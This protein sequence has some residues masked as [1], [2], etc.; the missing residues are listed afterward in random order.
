[1]LRIRVLGELTLELDGEALPPP[2][3]RRLRAL[4]G[5]LALHPGMHARAE[6]AGRLWPDV[7]DESARTSLR[8]A[9]AD[10]RRAVGD[11]HVV[12][13][14]DAVGLAPGVWIDARAFDELVAE[15]RLDE[16]LALVRGEVLDG[17][18]EEWVYAERDRRGEAVREALRRLAAEAE[19]AGDLRTAIARTR[20][21]IVADPLAE[22]AHRDLI[23]RL[24]AAGDRP[25]A[26]SAYIQLRELLAR[27]LQIAP[28]AQTRALVTQIH[29]TET[30]AAA[31]P[32]LPLPPAL[33]RRHRSPFV[34]RPE[35]LA[36]LRAAFDRAGDGRRLVLLTGEPGIGK[37][38]LAAE[39][40]RAVHG[41]GAT[42]LY[43]RAQEEPL[44]PYQPF[45]EALGPF[46]AARS[47]DALLALAGP[48]A[49][50]LGRLVPAEV[51]RLPPLVEAAT[52]DPA[53]ARYRLFEAAAALVAGAAR[54]RPLLLVLDDLHWADGPT[55]LLL[56]HLANAP[57][58]PALVLGTYRPGEQSAA[59][60]DALADLRREDR[61]DRIAVEGLVHDDV[62]ALVTAWLGRDAP[63]AL[64]DTVCR[65]TDGNPFFVEELL[66]QY[67]ESDAG[68]RR[69]EP[70]VPEG[71][72]EVL[73]RRLAR[74][75]DPARDTLL[76]AAVAGREVDLRLLEEAGELP[77]EALVEAL[78]AGLGAHLIREEAGA[79]GRYAFTHA[80]AREAIYGELSSARRALLHGR[81]A[82]AL[83]S[84]DADAAELAH[85]FLAAGGPRENVIEHAG[86]AGRRALAQ[87]AYEEAARH[88]ER[89]LDL[90][91]DAGELLIGLGDARL[92]AGDVEAS[93]ESFSSAAAVARRRR[94]GELLARAALGRSGLGATVLGHDPET[95]AVLEDALATLGGGSAALRARLLGRLAIELYHSPPV[96]RREELSA[97][98][99]AL[100]REA[101]DP[102]A[103]ADALSARHV[104]LWSPPHLDERLAL[105]DEMVALAE[106][107][108]DR[109]H[110]LQGRNWRVLDLLER[111]DLDAARREIDEHGR[112]ADDLRL[113][114]YQWWTPM[115][116]AMLAF[117]EGRL[118][119]AER[120]RAEAVEI[121]RRA[122]DRVADLFSWIQTVFVDLESEPIAP[123]APTDVPDRLA[124][125]AVQSAFRSD[126]PLIYAEM[127]R[128]DDARRE[129]EALAA[130]RFAGVAGDM[131]WLA[132]MVE[133]GQG[134]ALL[135]AREH[136][137]ELYE[138][139]LPYRRRSVLV[140]RAALCLG[141]VELH[142][143]VLATALGRYDDAERHLDAAARWAAAAGARPWA[144]WTDVHRAELLA[145]RGEAEAAAAL[146]GQAASKAEALGWGRAAGRARAVVSRLAEPPGPA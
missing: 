22:D 18:A 72:R 97:Q 143:G 13:T 54:E 15:R 39:L 49:G 69:W 138:L 109:E 43:G 129:L 104:A 118:Q 121:G 45:A 66:R 127:G 117:L 91:P 86:R 48:L 42:V 78:D 71:V 128:T 56:R 53:G 120:L 37:T 16:A 87:L 145:A 100:A 103:L 57:L 5:W 6:V 59:L 90:A 83:E 111:G 55:L 98:A 79:P 8:T 137:A 105:A 74:L 1:M 64:T 36:T 70:I 3:G 116:G 63:E 144:A 10:L 25:A 50:E 146:A 2:P 32:A 51:A 88:F 47:Q 136:A 132:S 133:L 41:A 89:A 108:G 141:P 27:D 110:A 130:D 106:A 77:R 122:S 60:A 19:A 62:D 93:R 44:A 101:G 113:P 58:G 24:A 4:L 67:A 75:G 119:D 140:G 107:D 21:Q 94:D 134:A 124:V 92:R 95:V 112:L 34:G 123:T 33:A 29:S 76:L 85:H 84:L 26:L 114:G 65:E 135:G 9:L 68:A 11:G 40:A 82:A 102:S 23:R 99:V 96:A 30:A 38:R 125:Q 20:E 46:L 131:N 28:S 61:L 35:E 126:L 81:V 52:R 142:L 14:R 7:L 17:L 12:A 73:G 139:L 31:T 115:W 80:L